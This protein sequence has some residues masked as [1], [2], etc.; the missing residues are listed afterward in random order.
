MKLGEAKEQRY[1]NQQNLLGN[2]TRSKP[3]QWYYEH[4]YNNAAIGQKEDLYM[5]SPCFKRLGRLKAMTCLVSGLLTLSLI[6]S[7]LVG[8][9]L[10]ADPSPTTGRAPVTETATAVSDGVELTEPGVFGRAWDSGFVVFMTLLTLVLASILCW[11]IIVVKWIEFKKVGT[12]T[13]SFVKTFWDSRSL[14]DL[15]GRLGDYPYSPAREVFR[16]G[17]A[18]LARSNQMRDQAPSM[19]VA[20]GAAMDNLN[21]SLQKSKLLERKRLEKNLPYL[22]IIASVTP[23]IGLFGTVWGIMNSFE[24]IA[25]TGSASLAAVAPGISEALIATAFGLAA[26]I[27]ALIAYNLFNGKLRGQMMSLDGFCADFLNIVER[28]LVTEKS[29]ILDK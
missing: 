12:T 21:R 22:A 26:A 3:Y 23:F 10:N 24:G 1:Y 11:V 17:Y 16:S 29:K 8:S 2:L 27:P 20:V 4:Q 18:E 28:Y 19:E 15:N 25:R 13:D 6:L 14:N 7:G 9:Q 5:L